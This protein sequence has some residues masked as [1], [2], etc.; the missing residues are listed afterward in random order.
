MDYN[1][2]G[3]ECNQRAH[4]PSG[5]GTPWSGARRVGGTSGY[6][7]RARSDSSGGTRI[8]QKR[9]A[10]RPRSAPLAPSFK[11][12]VSLCGI[13]QRPLTPNQRTSKMKSRIGKRIRSKSKIKSRSAVQWCACLNLHLTLPHL[14]NHNP[15]LDLTP[16]AS[17]PAAAELHSVIWAHFKR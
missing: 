1:R 2:L 9:R 6:S 13:P 14:H 3:E 4:V 7:A 17:A 11:L 5:L 8:Q 16:L 15:H 10:G 12:P